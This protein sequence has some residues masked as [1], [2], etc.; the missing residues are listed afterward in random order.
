MICSASVLQ[1][2]CSTWRENMA[3][4]HSK[5]VVYIP[6]AAKEYN[7]LVTYKKILTADKLKMNYLLAELLPTAMDAYTTAAYKVLVQWTM[8]MKAG[9]RSTW[10]GAR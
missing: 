2:E 6:L 9:T 7:F 1:G 8:N 5:G 10:C 3:A 4:A